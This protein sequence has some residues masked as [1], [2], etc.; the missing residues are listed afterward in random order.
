[1]SDDKIISGDT[2]IV[3]PPDLYSSRLSGKL[4]ERAPY[5][6]RQKLADGKES[7]AWFLG[8][9]QVVTLGAVTQAGRRFEDPEKIDFVGVWEDVREGTYR[10]SAMLTELEVDGI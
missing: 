2:H 9:T 1:M 7:D 6:K 5:M 3:E 10:P 4:K 8:D